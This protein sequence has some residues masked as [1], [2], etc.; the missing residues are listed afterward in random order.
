DDSGRD[1]FRFAYLGENKD[2]RTSQQWRATYFM[3]T[4]LGHWTSDSC[5]RTHG[6]RFT[7]MYAE[8]RRVKVNRIMDSTKAGRDEWCDQL[9]SRI[10]GVC[11][12]LKHRSDDPAT[13]FHT[14]ANDIDESR[15]RENALKE[16]ERHRLR[17]Q[18]AAFCDRYIRGYYFPPLPNFR[19]TEA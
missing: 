13:Y 16:L 3:E 7:A 2:R 17:S 19:A 15:Y 9:I 6:H 1:T 5:F 11:A 12:A 8:Q 4:W 10:R 14:R 18:D